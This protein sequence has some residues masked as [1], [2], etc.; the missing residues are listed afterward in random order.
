MR[1]TVEMEVGERFGEQ[2]GEQFGGRVWRGVRG[3]K[4]FAFY[5]SKS[6]L[7][8]RRQRTPDPLPLDS[9]NLAAS[10]ARWGTPLLSAP[11]NG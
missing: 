8:E 7:E 9:V 2:F 11:F 6:P 5:A 3:Q 1:P 10:N 4:G